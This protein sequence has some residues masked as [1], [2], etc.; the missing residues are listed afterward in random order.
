MTPEALASVEIADHCR[1]LACLRLPG[2]EHPR[3]EQISNDEK[4]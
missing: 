1:G 4:R 3:G 2:S